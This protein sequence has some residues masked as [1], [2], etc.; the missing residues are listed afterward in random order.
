MKALRSG[1]WF[2]ALQRIDRALID[3]T[4]KVATIVRNPK[5]VKS[6]FTIITKL[7]GIMESRRSRACKEI[8]LHLAHKLSLTAQKLGNGSAKSWATD[9]SFAR[10]LAVMFLNDSKMFTK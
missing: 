2:K 3:L 1:V 9:F 4:I 10:F 6:I 8:G 5:L 7:E